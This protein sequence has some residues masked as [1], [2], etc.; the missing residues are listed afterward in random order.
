MSR[1][2]VLIKSLL[3][4]ILQDNLEH[5]HQLLEQFDII[6]LDDVLA[7]AQKT[8]AHPYLKTTLIPT[9]EKD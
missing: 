8:F 1:A 9:H 7:I 6:E 3:K 2:Q 4:T 5:F